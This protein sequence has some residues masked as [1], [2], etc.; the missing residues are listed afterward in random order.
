[1]Q[2]DIKKEERKALIMASLLRKPGGEEQPD[3]I[4]IS[5]FPVGPE[6][7]EDCEKQLR[8]QPLFPARLLVTEISFTLK[9]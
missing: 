2:E 7:H 1:M 6:V 8:Q 3:H 4:S 5:S 9:L